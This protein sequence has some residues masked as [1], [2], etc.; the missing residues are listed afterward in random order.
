MSVPN[1]VGIVLSFMDS[2]SISTEITSVGPS[3]PRNF[4]CNGAI[5]SLFL[6]KISMYISDFLIFSCTSTVLISSSMIPL[7]SF[8]PG[9]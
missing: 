6:S 1:I 3:L 9:P 7:I 4:L 5:A 8:V 2:L